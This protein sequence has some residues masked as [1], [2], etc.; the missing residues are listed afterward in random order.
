M[1]LKLLLL[2]LSCSCFG[3]IPAYYSGIDFS[4]SGFDSKNFE[5]EF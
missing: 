5:I 3:Q 2:L 4:Q 1:K